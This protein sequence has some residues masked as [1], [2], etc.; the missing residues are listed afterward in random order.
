MSGFGAV[1]IKVKVWKQNRVIK[2]D[3][4]IN[5]NFKS[6]N[7]S[8]RNLPIDSIILH[9]TGGKFPGCR[10]WLIDITSMVSSHYLINKQGEVYSLVPDE[11]KAWHAGRSAFDLNGDGTISAVERMWNDRTIGIEMEGYAEDNYKYETEQLKSL[12]LLV[13][14]LLYKYKKMTT[15]AILGHKEISP[16][17]KFDPAN[18]DMETFRLKMRRWMGAV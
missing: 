12:D 9:H 7:F 3:L 16:G 4:Y 8:H 13:Y 1:R 10:S 5:T 14:K 17:R 11:L 2:K 15:Y 6:P 18:F